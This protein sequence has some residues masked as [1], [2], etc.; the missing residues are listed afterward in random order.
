VYVYVLSRQVLQCRNII[1]FNPFYYICTIFPQVVRTKLSE[2]A[3]LMRYFFGE[4][5][6]LIEILDL[7]EM[8]KNNC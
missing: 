2:I 8:E 7:D 6:R 1:G 4:M 5:G 3:C